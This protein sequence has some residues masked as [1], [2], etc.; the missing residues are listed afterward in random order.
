MSMGKAMLWSGIFQTGGAIVQ[1]IAQGKAIDRQIAANI[2]K[3]YYGVATEASGERGP[4]D[5]VENYLFE[6]ATMPQMAEAGDNPQEVANQM[7]MNQ[8][9]APLERSVG[10][11]LGTQPGRPYQAQAPNGLAYTPAQMMGG[12]GLNNPRG[13][14]SFDPRA[15]AQARPGAGGPMSLMPAM[16]QWRLLGLS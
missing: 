12:P 7:A 6:G 16:D 2:P 8:A 13:L 14:M 9:N 15:A 3:A 11:A 5:P 4:N 1:G 10:N